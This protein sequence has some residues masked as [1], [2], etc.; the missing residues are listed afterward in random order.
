M[1][2]FLYHNHPIRTFCSYLSLF[3]AVKTIGS[4]FW[5]L[6]AL[7][8]RRV[9][10]L[11]VLQDVL[12]LRQDLISNGFFNNSLYLY[13]YILNRTSKR[14]HRS[15]DRA[16]RRRLSV[17]VQHLPR[18]GDA[19]ARD[20]G[21][22]DQIPGILAGCAGRSHGHGTGL[23]RADGP[24]GH[25]DD[26]DQITIYWRTEPGRHTAIPAVAFSILQAQGP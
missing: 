22:R 6:L 7:H 9:P 24:P 21:A 5:F 18:P 8:T 25:L 12:Q 3:R 13:I 17:L 23:H 11:Y 1:V 26:A 14:R 4:R 10:V 2:R 15:S 19:E 16:R 20:C